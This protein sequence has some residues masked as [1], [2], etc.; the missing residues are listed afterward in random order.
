MQANEFLKSGL[1]HME[2][3]A[4]TYDAKNG[5]RSAGKTV[6]MFNELTGHNLTNVDFWRLMCCL[7]LVRGSQGAFRADNYEDL[8]A[9]AGLAGEE[10]YS[11]SQGDLRPMPKND[12][13]INIIGQNGNTGEHYEVLPDAVIDNLTRFEPHQH[14][15][16]ARED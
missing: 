4:K 10:A 11:A 8:A 1:A 16:M 15:E 7:K 9:Y 13:R 5:E 14:P 2:D 12:D 6:A 3:R